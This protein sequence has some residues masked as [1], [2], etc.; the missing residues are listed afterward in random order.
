MNDTVRGTS[1]L[2][3]NAR[4]ELASQVDAWERNEVAKFV[5]RAPERQRQFATLGGFPLKRTYTA[6]AGSSPTRTTDS[7][8]V[9]PS[10]L[11]RSTSAATSRRT[12][13]PM[14]APSISNAV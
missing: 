4:T 11:R 7:P 3:D 5:S 6:L 12:R 9:M 8:G 2:D 1:A 14:A 13:R 10:A